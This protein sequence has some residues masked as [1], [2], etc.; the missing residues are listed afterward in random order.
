MARVVA[1]L[2]SDQVRRGWEVTVA[3]PERGPLM[4]WAGA[5]PARTIRWD[6]TRDPGVHSLGEITRL[7]RVIQQVDPEVVH[8]H[9][10]KAGLAGRLAVRGRRC[11]LFQPHGWSFEAVTGPMRRGIIL[12]ERIATGWSDAI[13]CVSAAEMD[14]G[15]LMGIRARYRVAPNGIDLARFPYANED[16]RVAARRRLGLDSP[17]V[18]VGL[19]RLHRAKGQD[20]LL[21]AW[22]IVLTSVPRARL[23]LVGDG[24]E[25]KSLAQR[26]VPQV[27]FVGN[28]DDVADWLAAANVVALPSRWEAGLPLAA[29]EAMACGR[30]VVATDA[31]GIREGLGGDSGAVVPIDDGVALAGAIVQ[32]LRDPA[33]ARR[34]GQSGRRRVGRFHDLR[35]T[36]AAVERLYRECL[37]NRRR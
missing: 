4:A 2:A 26:R 9:S 6:A 10:S 12:W 7:A 31:I 23:V 17:A 13:I 11:T 28:Q 8:L 36:P 24:P 25:R 21:D 27:S 22:P 18:V 37:K 16:E 15:K 3:C 32:R 30:S 20:V 35:V 19:G 14:R 33:T 5:A 1:D 29:I 34:E